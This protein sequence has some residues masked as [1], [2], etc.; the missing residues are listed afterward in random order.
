M[1]EPAK[2]HRDR[3]T[4]EREGFARKT[5]VPLTLCGTIWLKAAVLLCSSS[6]WQAIFLLNEI[7]IDVTYNDGKRGCWSTLFYFLFFEAENT[8]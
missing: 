1:E 4:R 3:Q 8:F 5:L 7:K 6:T 2:G